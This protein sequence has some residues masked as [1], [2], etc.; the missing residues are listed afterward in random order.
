MRVTL[1]GMTDS[2]PTLSPGAP[3]LTPGAAEISPNAATLSPAAARATIDALMPQVKTWLTELVAFASVHGDD[4]LREANEAAAQWVTARFNELGVPAEMVATVD[5]SYTISG[6]RPASEGM[7]T[8]LLYSHFDVQPATDVENWESSP[9]ELT[10][11][12]GRWY[13]RGTADCKGNVVMH[14]AA[15]HALAEWE[16]AHPE[17]PR[18]G[19]RIICEGSEE[20]G[21]EGLED[22]LANRPE[23]FAADAFMIADSGNDAAG[24]PALGVA[25]RGSAGV[26]VTL[27]TLEAPVHSGVFGG[28]APDALLAMIHLLATLHDEN[29]LLQVEGLPTDGSWT[30]STVHTEDFR[31]NAGILPGVQIFGAAG[32]T[33]QGLEGG[34]A[35][36]PHNPSIVDLT[37]AQ[38]AI[39]VTALDAVPV[40]D[41]INAVPAVCSAV[42]NLRVPPGQDPLA[43]QDA[44]VAHLEKHTPWGAQLTIER[45]S[46]S[47]PFHADTSGPLTSIMAGALTD[48]Y[49]GTSTIFTASGGSIPLCNALLDAYPE[50]ELALYGVEDPSCKIHSANESVDP[51]EIRHIAVGEL[52]FLT[53][54]GR[55]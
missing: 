4:A 24:E 29:G 12:D 14:F 27:R 35:V 52:L 28:A 22:L 9:W 41:V 36:R 51:E 11:R 5:G 53:R 40:R 17:A 48:A 10:E 26:T 46:V 43:L 7:P 30:T 19:I 34:S 32:T 6:L 44:L 38:P 2:S 47:Q 3:E 16:S 20:R 50:A 15:L 37:V 49:D 33:A 31:A 13:G 21:G 42:L 55:G 1:V 23:L 18:L 39:T 54:Y 8:V 45:E 25:L